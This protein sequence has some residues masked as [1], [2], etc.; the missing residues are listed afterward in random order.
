MIVPIIVT[1]FAHP[2]FAQLEHRSGDAERATKAYR[3]GWESMRAEEWGK[4][5]KHFQEAIAIDPKFT[6]AFYS[7]GRAQMGLRQ[8]TDAIE[9]YERCQSLYLNVAQEQFSTVMDSNRRRDELI[10]QYTVAIQQ[11]TANRAPNQTQTQYIQQLKND[12][13]RLENARGRNV[14]A[15]DI[16]PGVPFF[17]SLALGSAYFRTERFTDAERAYKAAIEANPSSGESHNNLAVVYMLTNRFELAD[18][19]VKAAEKLGFKVSEQF[20]SDLLA[21]RKTS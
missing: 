9:S 21:K 1:L 5:A 10:Q 14:S 15:V 19:E 20:K 11:A 6:L 3:S 4:A 16:T 2:V 7:L 17:V 12:V 13:Q 8:F 18:G